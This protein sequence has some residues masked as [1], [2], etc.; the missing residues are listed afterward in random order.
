[1]EAATNLAARLGYDTT[2]LTLP[3]VVRDSDVAQPASIGVPILVGRT[4]RFVQSLVDAKTLDVAAL[5]PGQGLIA[6]VAS[7]LG[8]GDGLVVVGGDDEGTL[9]AGIELAARLPRVWGMNGITLPAVEDQALRYLRAHGVRPARPRSTSMLVDSDKRGVARIACASRCPTRT[10]RVRQKCSTSSS[11]RIGAARSR[12]RSISRTSP[13]TAIDIVAARESIAHVDVSRTGLN[14]RTLTPPIDPDE[15]APDSPGDRGRPADAAAGRRSGANLRSDERALD[16][17]LVRRRVHRSDSGSHRHHDCA[18]R[19][20]R[21]RCRA[22]HIAAR[23]GLETTGITLPL[24]RDRR[25][26]AD[27]RA[28]A[29]PDSRR[30]LQRA[31][32]AAREDRQS[33]AR[34]SAAR[35]G[36]GADR[37]RGRSATPPRPSWPAPTPPAPT[38]PRSTS[39]AACR[40]CGTTRAARSRLSDVAPQANRFLQART[41]AGQASQSTPSS[42]RARRRQGQDDRVVRREAVRR[43]GRPGARQVRRREAAARAASRRR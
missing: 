15:L 29:E 28:R 2:A 33:A 8:G 25:Q 37:A 35:R 41:A 9:N 17:R 32:R 13:T 40:T 18:R 12:R 10:V 20:R 22:A 21:I 26:G 6:V 31:R 39:R 36:R 7:P 42:T 23:L 5:K 30:P 38:R 14:Q 16:R 34:R 19:R 11:S 27:A 4:N 3:L 43:A 1:M 24:T